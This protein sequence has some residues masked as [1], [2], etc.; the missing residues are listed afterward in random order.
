M[1]LQ[2]HRNSENYMFTL[3][4]I[5]EYAEGIGVMAKPQTDLVYLCMGSNPR[6]LVDFQVSAHAISPLV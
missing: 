3:V 2:Q 6:T 4:I 5:M 1:Q